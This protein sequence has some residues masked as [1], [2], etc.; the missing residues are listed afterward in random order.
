MLD[1]FARAGDGAAGRG[2]TD[3]GEERNIGFR[4]DAEVRFGCRGSPELGE[5]GG[6]E[7]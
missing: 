7:V 3:R 5:V 1:D 2:V 4:M 6:F